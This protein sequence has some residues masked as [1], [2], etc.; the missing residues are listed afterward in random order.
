MGIK[1]MGTIPELVS[2]IK[3]YLQ[4]HQELMAGPKFQKLY[5]YQPGAVGSK[6]SKSKGKNSA[7]KDAEDAAENAKLFVP[8][9]G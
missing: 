3:E 9:T 4:A 7:D 8:A 2:H 1:N 6:E 5:M